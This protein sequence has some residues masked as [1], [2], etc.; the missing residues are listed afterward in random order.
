MVPV[1]VIAMQI[2]LMEDA[3]FALRLDLYAN[4]RDNRGWMNLFR[5]WGRSDVST[6]ASVMLHWNYSNDFVTFYCNYIQDWREID[7]ARFRTRGTSRR[8]WT[9]TTSTR[10][11]LP[12]S[13]RN[14]RPLVCS[15]TMGEWKR[16]RR[17]RA[18]AS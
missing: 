2:Q 10:T 9:R 3:Y 7:S 11:R 1:N 14:A 16:V 4:A 13:A 6:T 18:S 5:R 15:R 17:N 12:S 8:T